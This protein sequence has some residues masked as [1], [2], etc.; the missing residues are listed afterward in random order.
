MANETASLDRYDRK[1]VFVLSQDFSAFD[2]ADHMADYIPET[3][4]DGRRIWDMSALDLALLA[5]TSY[6]GGADAL[7]ARMELLDA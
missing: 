6:P 4:P 7:Q 3:L 2:L 1:A 5:A